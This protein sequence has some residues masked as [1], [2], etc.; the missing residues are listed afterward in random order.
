MCN[1]AA[2]IFSTVSHSSLRSSLLLFSSQAVQDRMP[3]IDMFD[4]EG[5]FIPRQM[6]EENKE[7]DEDK[8]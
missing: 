7:D 2:A 4:D 1:V 5:R 8:K 3:S 6:R